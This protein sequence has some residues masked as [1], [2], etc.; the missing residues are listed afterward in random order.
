MARKSATQ[1]KA[2]KKDAG[3]TEEKKMQL[4][5]EEWKRA[6]DTFIAGLEVEMRIALRH[7][8]CMNAGSIADNCGFDS[9]TPEGR[10]F[11]KELC[12]YSLT[13]YEKI[14]EIATGFEMKDFMKVECPDLFEDL[15]PYVDDWTSNEAKAQNHIRYIIVMAY[16]NNM[17][18]MHN[19]MV[20]KMQE[21]GIEPEDAASGQAMEDE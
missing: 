13:V 14:H 15:M 9:N 18:R 11:A 20:K 12:R 2:V 4:L 17:V 10:E 8:K 6:K 5:E 1:V 7:D 16:G 19:V 21:L 3:M